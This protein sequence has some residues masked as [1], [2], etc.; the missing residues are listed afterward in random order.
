MSL[1]PSATVRKALARTKSSV[2][3]KLT[4]RMPGAPADTQTVTLKGKS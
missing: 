4:L 3:V 2:R 1:K